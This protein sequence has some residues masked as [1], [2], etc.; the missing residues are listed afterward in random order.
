MSTHAI[1]ASVQAADE[2]VPLNPAESY[3][4]YAVPALFAPAAERLLAA[5]AP[6]PGERVLDVGTGT[7]IVARR[8][9]PLVGPTGTVA[10]VDASAGMLSVA[11]ET[12]ARE[13]IPISWHE[14][15]AESL[16][17]PDASFD[18]VLCQFALMFFNDVP[19]ALAEMRRVLTPD[20]RAVLS[21]FQA[22]D[23][24][25]FY[26]ALDQA[27]ERRLGIPAVAAIFSLSDA[28]ALGEAISRAGF[29]EVE[30]EPWSMT[31][32]MGPPDAFLAGEIEMDTA[33]IPAMQDLPPAER[34]KLVEAIAQDLAEPLRAV[35][36]GG[37]VE[38]EFHTLVAR[39]TR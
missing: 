14:G 12:A 36:V 26:A 13:D 27:I 11:R 8:V 23:L 6:V 19:T 18:L 21:V 28:D 39:A 15:L 35:T 4:R 10:G 29:R 34:R 3:E 32:H 38:M 9:A 20:G 24:H 30:I 5:A 33:A 31:A 22:I 7:G 1:D 25:P 16:P 2:Q 17:F 37:K